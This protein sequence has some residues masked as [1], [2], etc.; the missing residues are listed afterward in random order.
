MTFQSHTSR[1]RA[2]W[3]SCPPSLCSR[4][5]LTPAHAGLCK[6][7]NSKFTRVHNSSKHPGRGASSPRTPKG[8]FSALDLHSCPKPTATGAPGCDTAV[9]GTKTGHFTRVKL[10]R[11]GSR[12]K[13]STQ[14]FLPTFSNQHDEHLPR[15]KT[16]VGCSNSTA[17][18]AHP[19]SE[20]TSHFSLMGRLIN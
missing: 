18:L 11:S 14:P 12:N 6:S 1:S 13:P 5:Q 3:L 7:E 8:R 19:Q 2:G 20:N 16:P 15:N 10:E 17:R 4:A 9:V